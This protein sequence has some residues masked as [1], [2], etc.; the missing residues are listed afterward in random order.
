MCCAWTQQP[1]RTR[2]AGQHIRACGGWLVVVAWLRWWLVAAGLK[3]VT[4][5]GN[6]YGG[7]VCN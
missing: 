7:T 6:A 2:R 5:P 4:V 3:A 1:R